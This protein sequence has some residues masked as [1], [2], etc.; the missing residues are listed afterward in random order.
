MQK[1]FKCEKCGKTQHVD[2]KKGIPHA[3]P[4]CCGQSMRFISNLYA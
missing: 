3:S 2:A 4:K 1:L